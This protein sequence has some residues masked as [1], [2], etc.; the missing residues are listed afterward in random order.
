MKII[1]IIEVKTKNTS[2]WVKKHD[3]NENTKNKIKYRGQDLWLGSG[4]KPV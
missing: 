4:I 1:K 3:N 2:E